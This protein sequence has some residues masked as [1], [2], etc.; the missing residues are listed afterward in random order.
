LQVVHAIIR[1][2]GLEEALFTLVSHP[3]DGGWRRRDRA[4]ARVADLAPISGRELL[5]T[6]PADGLERLRGGPDHAVSLSSR[7]QGTTGFRHLALM[8]L[9]VDEAAPPRAL[10]D[11]VR[12]T[13]AG[14]RWWLLRTGGGHHLYCDRLLEDDALPAWNERFLTPIVLA[15]PRYVRQCGAWGRNLLRLT[16]RPGAWPAAPVTVETQ[17]GPRGAPI[18]ERAME[19]ARARHGWRERPDGEPVVTHLNA[20]ATTAVHIRADC[21]PRG[22]ADD[23]AGSLEELYA[24]GYLHSCLDDTDARYEDVEAA[25]GARVA[26]WVA[27]LSIDK[28]LPR[29]RRRHA[30]RTQLATASRPARIVKLADLLADLRAVERDPDAWATRSPADVAGQLAQIRPGLDVCPEFREAERILDGWLRSRG[31]PT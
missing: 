23:D 10:T 29:D 28:R 6:R 30:H 16:S 11:A 3:M 7:F 13:C 4:G 12:R 9:I 21:W 5:R 19:L 25:A 1:L 26:A 18:V 2:H 27:E 24:C 8:D 14:H 15:D 17:S 22:A 20:V 31:R